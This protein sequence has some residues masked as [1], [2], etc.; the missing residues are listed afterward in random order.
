M[1]K[2]APRVGVGQM[3]A[4]GMRLDH[5]L[6]DGETDAIAARAGREE[7]FEDALADG[8]RHAGS[9][10]AHDDVRPAGRRRGGRA[11]PDR[12]PQ[13]PPAGHWWRDS[14]RRKRA[15]GALART[16]RSGASV[17]MV[18]RTP[19]RS[20]GRSHWATCSSSALMLTSFARRATVCEGQH[21]V[22]QR[23][24]LL[25]AQHGSFGATREVLRTAL[26]HAHL[27]CIQ[28]RGRKRRANLVGETRGQLPQGEQA[29]LARQ[30]HLH[31]M[32]LGHV[33]QQHDLAAVA[34]FAA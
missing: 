3:H 31:E 9:V 27:R 21:V 2:A 5:F 19:R 10:I 26:G 16:L 32:R 24:E 23:I 25:Q 12:A 28:Q 1:T 7:R 4:S 30:E 22:H 15:T 8:K 17:R 14:A 20:A 18:S 13:S 29:L 11:I 33:G 34:R 6:D